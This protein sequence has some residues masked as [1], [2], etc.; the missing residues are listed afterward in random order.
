MQSTSAKQH[1]QTVSGGMTLPGSSQSAACAC[2]SRTAS[3]P[4]PPTLARLEGP[5]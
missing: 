2:C 1:L 3:K 4:K 5:G